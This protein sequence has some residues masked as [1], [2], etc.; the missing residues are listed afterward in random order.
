[1]KARASGSPP[2]APRRSAKST[3]PDPGPNQI[4]AR[5]VANGICMFEV[6][7]YS[8]KEPM[9]PRNVGH[10]GVGVVTKVGR[11]VKHIREGDWVATFNWSTAVNMDAAGA[12][13]F[14][15]RPA[16]PA[17]FIAEP[18]SCVVTALYSY[19]LTPGDRVLVLG[20]GYMGLLNVQ[21]L[22]HCPLAELVVTD[23]KESNLALAQAVRRHRGHQQRDS[24]RTGAARG[25]ETEAL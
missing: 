5:T 4:Q 13:V 21:G 12:A 24:R 22:A 23:I 2:R 17:L 11:D 18:P 3:W 1:M 20:A 7:V 16:D 8:G 19:D 25:V 6:S 9:Y 10:E 14:S 15:R